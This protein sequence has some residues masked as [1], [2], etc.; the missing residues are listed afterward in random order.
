MRHNSAGN[1]R[2]D[3]GT[4]GASS[5]GQAARAGRCAANPVL[6]NIAIEYTGT[7]GMASCPSGALLGG[8][9]FRAQRGRQRLKHAMLTLM[10]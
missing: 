10:L 1:N 4:H 9:D 3:N 6:I 2:S 7:E 5:R 8:E